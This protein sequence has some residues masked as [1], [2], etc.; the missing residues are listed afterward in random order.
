M[1][2]RLHAGAPDGVDVHIDDPVA[3]WPGHP[4]PFTL[5]PVLAVARHS[6][7]DALAMLPVRLGAG[8]EPTA[9]RRWSALGIPVLRTSFWRWPFG[10]GTDYLACATV[11]AL[12]AG[13][14]PR[15]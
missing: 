9:S 6:A 14:R 12:P 8:G 15:A 13:L 7:G 2:P 1:V 10:P 4:Q 3:W 5:D 11:A